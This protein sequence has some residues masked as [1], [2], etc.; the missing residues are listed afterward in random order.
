MKASIHN[1]AGQVIGEQEL[2]PR[3]FSVTPDPE[4][5]HAIVT[6]VQANHRRAIGHTKTRAEVRGGGRKPWKQKGTGRARHGSSR[7]PLWIG[8]GITFGPRGTRNYTQ[9]INKSALRSAM[10]MCL[11]A[12]VADAHF[13][14][15]NTLLLETVKTQNVQK[16]L[17]A[18]NIPLQKKN[19]ALLV[20][21]EKVSA[22]V[23][24]ARNIP[25]LRTIGKEN[26]NVYDVLRY[27]YLVTTP[28]VVAHLTRVYAGKRTTGA[29]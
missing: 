12:K 7:S 3:V 25:S 26:M 5:L 16:I 20:A 22:L 23:R 9:K 14:L 13:I 19:A 21:S 18:L 4:F 27:P 15:V 8:G 1:Q 10:R 28:E 2:D 6:A 24:V 11:S 29:Q 17:K